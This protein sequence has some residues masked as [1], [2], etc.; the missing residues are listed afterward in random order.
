MPSAQ[1][2]VADTLPPERVGNGAAFNQVGMNIGMLAGPLVGGILFKVHGPE[3]AYIVIAVLYFMGGLATLLIRGLERSV[4]PHRE[5]VLRTIIEGL[6]YVKGE[7]VL[8]RTGS[9]HRILGMDLP[10]QFDTD[11][12]RAGVEYRF[13]RARLVD[14]RLWHGCP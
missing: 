7:Q 11:I 5:S 14:V 8:W 2:L 13:C 10:Y 1:S 3:G 6:K 12:C 4:I 9:N